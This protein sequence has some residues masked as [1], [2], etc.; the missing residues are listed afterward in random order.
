MRSSPDS[1]ATTATAHRSAASA[2]TPPSWLTI[3]RAI[4]ALAIAAA[5]LGQVLT[6]LAFWTARGDASIPLDLL[7]FFSFFSIESNLLAMVS[8]AALV[9]IAV[10]RRPVTRGWHVLALCAT[11]YMVTT[12]IVY[13]I[14]LRGI[15]LPQGA[16]LAWSNEILHLVAPVWMLADW[17]LASRE[18]DV[19]WGDA[20]IVAIYPVAWL[21][22]TLVRGPVT[23]DQATGDGSW[24]PYPFLDPADG[25]YGPVIVTC[26]VIATTI[27]LLSLAL[28][29]RARSA[30][31]TVAG[32]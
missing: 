18:R 21:A 22:Y 5:V 11:T 8:L 19:R 3:V 9:V 29:A 13:N 20:A 32:G 15:E 17:L 30:A 16:T 24:Y 31:R 6:S 12:G 26:A 27:V 4:V 25:G 14:L 23:P 2:A 1:A 28:I 7:N 10:Q